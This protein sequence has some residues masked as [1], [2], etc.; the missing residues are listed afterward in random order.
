MFISATK[1][2]SIIY[3]S[4]KMILNYIVEAA[5]FIL[6]KNVIYKYMYY[7]SAVISLGRIYIS[8]LKYPTWKMIFK[9]NTNELHSHS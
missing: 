9:Q 3:Y 6:P 5:V 7:L 8:K 4:Y 1:K 2:N